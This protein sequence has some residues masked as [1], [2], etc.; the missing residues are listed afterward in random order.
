MFLIFCAL[1]EWRGARLERLVS[2][3][4]VRKAGVGG[5]WLPC[6]SAGWY[7]RCLNRSMAGVRAR[8]VASSFI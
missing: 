2:V 3:V 8:E 4:C 6:R 5:V 1:T 7:C